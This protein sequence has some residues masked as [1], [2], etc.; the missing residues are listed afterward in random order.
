[1][2]HDKVHNF[3]CRE[4]RMRTLSKLRLSAHALFISFQKSSE[5]QI[6]TVE[7]MKSTF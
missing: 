1:M 2:S 5:N 3:F 6:L 7:K 4:T